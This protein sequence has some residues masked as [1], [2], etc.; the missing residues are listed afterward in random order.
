LDPKESKKLKLERQRKHKKAQNNSNESISLQQAPASAMELAEAMLSP[1]TFEC[2]VDATL[3]ASNPA[4]AAVYTT[5]LQGFPTEGDSFAV[6]SNGNATVVAGSTEEFCSTCYSGNDLLTLNLQFLLSSNPGNLTFDW[7]FG[8]EELP[9]ST[10]PVNDFFNVLVNGA[11]ITNFPINVRNG[12]FAAPSPDDVC[13]NNITPTIQTASFDLTPYANQVITVSIQVS[14]I[15][16]CIFDSAAFIDNLVVEGCIPTNCGPFDTTVDFFCSVTVPPN[17]NVDPESALVGF[18]TD[19][20]QC[21][22]EPCFINVEIPNPFGDPLCCDV[23]INAVRAIG[24]IPFYVSVKGTNGLNGS[25]A[26]LS[27]RDVT[28]VDHVICLRCQDDENPCDSEFFNA[29]RVNAPVT[30]TLDVTDSNGNQI[31]TVS[32]TFQLPTCQAP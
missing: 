26:A 1:D 22:L 25:T 7:K 8:T 24:C 27:S 19:C 28:C 32:G 16:D 21:V 14:D 30:V 9:S 12:T 31:Y 3:T 5:S 4:Q 17:F 29:I 15:F 11:S 13:F 2:L 20:L 6:L 18:E 10:S 23:D